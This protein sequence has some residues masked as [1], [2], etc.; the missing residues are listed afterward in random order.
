MIRCAR[1]ETEARVAF[2]DEGRPLSM[3]ASFLAACDAIQQAYK[4]AFET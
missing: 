1:S 3:I 4:A 2:M